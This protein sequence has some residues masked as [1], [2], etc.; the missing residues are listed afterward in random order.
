MWLFDKLYQWVFSKKTSSP[1]LKKKIN[2]SASYLPHSYPHTPR[3]KVHD[4][5]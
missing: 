4:I 3:P 2:Y 5:N 1:S